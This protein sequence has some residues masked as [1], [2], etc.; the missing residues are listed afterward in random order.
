M[1][2]IKKQ[3]ENWQGIF[4]ASGQSLFYTDDDNL[5]VVKGCRRKI[6]GF[7]SS[8]SR[9]Q[10]SEEELIFKKGAKLYVSSDGFIDQN[11]LKREKFGSTRFTKT[12][13]KV[14]KYSMKHQLETLEN[15]LHLHQ[16]DELQR[17][18]ITVIGVQL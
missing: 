8:K 2:I 3:D 12:L 15:E 17:D 1:L 9:H 13:A 18:D 11:N 16:Q 4:G 6:G 10:F 5:E 7:M 14:Q